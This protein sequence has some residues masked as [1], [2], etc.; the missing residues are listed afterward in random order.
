MTVPPG[1]VLV[2]FGWPA[3]ISVR[4][5][6]RHSRLLPEEFNSYFAQALRR[7]EPETLCERTRLPDVARNVM[8]DLVPT[9]FR[10]QLRYRCAIVRVVLDVDPEAPTI[11]MLRPVL[12]PAVVGQNL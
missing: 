10:E 11:K 1:T 4:S 8:R 9:S 2:G 6:F 5:E 12:Q 7:P 3:L